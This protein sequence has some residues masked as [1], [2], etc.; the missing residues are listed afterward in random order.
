M[1]RSGYITGLLILLVAL[2]LPAPSFAQERPAGWVNGDGGILKF[3]IDWDGRGESLVRFRET[4]EGQLIQVYTSLT[5]GLGPIKL[6]RY[7]LRTDEL[8]RDGKLQKI[9]SA[10][11]ENGTQYEVRGKRTD[12]GF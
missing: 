10:V 8:W 1:T 7:T 11:D 2:A 6:F 3:Q 4:D 9:E 5:F 12:E